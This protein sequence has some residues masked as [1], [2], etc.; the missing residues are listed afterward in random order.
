MPFFGYYHFAAHALN[1]HKG[2]DSV[3]APEAE[4]KGRLGMTR[5]L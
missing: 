1:I 4:R 3:E 5:S 2:W